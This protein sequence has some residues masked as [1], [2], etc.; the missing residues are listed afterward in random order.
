M[1]I[2]SVFGG[3]LGGHRASPV[4]LGVQCWWDRGSWES[5]P[6]LYGAVP[7]LHVGQGYLESPSLLF[8]RLKRNMANVRLY[9]KNQYEVKVFVV[10]VNPFF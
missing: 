7:H 4:R 8:G 6:L 1:K 5:I 3:S 2:G 10:I 9:M